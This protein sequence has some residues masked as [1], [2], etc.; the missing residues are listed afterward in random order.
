MFDVL[1]L[2]FHENLN[3]AASM[4][5]TQSSILYQTTL[6]KSTLHVATWCYMTRGYLPSFSMI[7]HIIA[8]LE[9]TQLYMI[10]QQ[11]PFLLTKLETLIEWGIFCYHNIWRIVCCL[12]CRCW[13]G[14]PRQ[15]DL[16]SMMS[17][18]CR[19]HQIQIS[20]CKFYWCIP[21]KWCCCSC[22][23]CCSWCSCCCCSCC[24]CCF[25]CCRWWQW[26]WGSIEQLNNK[27]VTLLQWLSNNWVYT[28]L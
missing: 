26:W 27:T 23:C 15:S 6:L 4:K 18:D 8:Q 20:R 21:T 17:R 11:Y 14:T 13:C 25:C 12:Y 24:S 28:N 7:S 16:I 3:G 5:G 22:C 19:M 9:I 1:C 10:V 2:I